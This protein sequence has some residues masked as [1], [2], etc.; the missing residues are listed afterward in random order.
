MVGGHPSLMAC[1]CANNFLQDDCIHN[2]FREFRIHLSLLSVSCTESNRKYNFL[3]SQPEQS[4][5]PLRVRALKRIHYGNQLCFF[6]PHLMSDKELSLKPEVRKFCLIEL[7]EGECRGK[8]GVPGIRSSKAGMLWRAN[9]PQ[10][11]LLYGGFKSLIYF[12]VVG[13]MKD[14]K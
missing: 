4:A 11:A 7:L 10:I 5:H 14:P 6:W 2:P 1:I 12:D 8:R 9:S 13:L 3:R